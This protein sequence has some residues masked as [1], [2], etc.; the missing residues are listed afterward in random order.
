MRVQYL[1]PLEQ[2]AEL[3]PVVSLLLET[4]TSCTKWAEPRSSVCSEVI[5][6]SQYPLLPWLHLSCC[7]ASSVLVSRMCQWDHSV[8]CIIE[9]FRNLIIFAAYH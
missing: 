2:R 7:H 1:A 6:S 8:V 4:V 9:Q 3:A 5:L